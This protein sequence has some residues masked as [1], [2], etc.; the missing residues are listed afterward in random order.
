MRNALLTLL[1]LLVT[2]ALMAAIPVAIKDNGEVAVTFSQGNY[3][4][5]LISNDKIIEAAFP[6]NRMTIKRDGQ[7]GSVYLMLA[8]A[9]PFTLFL[10][11]EAGRHFALTVNGE[12]GLGKTVELKV[13]QAVVAQASPPKKE[14]KTVENPIPAAI[15]SLITQMERQEN[16]KGIEIKHLFGRAERL[17]TTLS[18][19]PKEVWLSPELKGEK[20]EV[21]NAGN[22]PLNL[23]ETWFA[24]EGI[25]AV[26][27]SNNT[28]APKARVY[29]YRVEERA[30]G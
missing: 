27:L 21:Y 3:N 22:T 15:V 9:N 20:I 24:K 1:G 25:K 23:E 4:R 2:P 18:L 26:K 11:T 30:H 19:I 16:V 8:D 6:P 17:G 12:E 10:T 14:Q 7:D 5:L 28:V 29:L 13:Q